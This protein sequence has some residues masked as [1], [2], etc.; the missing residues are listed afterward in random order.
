M[1]DL[2]TIL[3]PNAQAIERELEQ[4]SGRLLG[5]GDPIAAL[6]NASVCPEHLLSYLAWGF[7][8]EV[9][10]SSWSV[11][12][13]R[14]VLV[15]AVQVHRAKGTVGSVRRALSGIGF[16]TDI[17][18]WFDYAGDPHTFRVDAF[19]DDVFAAGMAIDSRTLALVTSILVNLKPERSHFELRIGERFDTAVYARAGARSRTRSD[20]SHDPNPR[21]R[22]SVGTTHMRVGSR[23]R[24]ISTVYHDVQPRDAA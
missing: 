18:E 14:Q 10:D 9:W 11:E 5:F 17:A 24:Q 19:G 16:R 6:W 2:P 3:P 13:K 20:L 4:L 23:A 7:S 15:D 21:T 12:Q 1:S 22:V 8:V